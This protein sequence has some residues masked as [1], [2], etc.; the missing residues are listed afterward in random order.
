MS[1]R[2]HDFASVYP[3]QLMS[4]SSNTSSS[5]DSHDRPTTPPKMISADHHQTTPQ[6]SDSKPQA[7]FLT[8]LYA[9]LERPENHHMI[10][11]DPAGEYIIV[12]RP[13][14]LALH[15]LP[16]IYRQSRFASFSRQLNIYG[17]MRK[18][19]LRNVDPAIDDPD[20]ST[21]SHPT[22]NRHSPPEVVQNFKR[23]VPPRLPKPRKRDSQEQPTIPPPRST[24]SMNSVSLSSPVTVNSSSQKTVVSAVGRARGFSAPG[25]FTPLNQGNTAAWSQNFTRAALPP[26]TVPSDPPQVSHNSLYSHSSHPTLHP[27]SLGTDDSP[28]SPPYSSISSYSASSRDLLVNSTHYNYSDQNSWSFTN[29]TSSSSS[30]NGSLS[31]LLNPS[32]SGYARPTPT[33]NTSYVS[34]FSSMPL[35]GEH[36]AS[37]L[38]SD[39]RPPTGYSVSSIPYQDDHFNHD[40]SRPSSGHRPISPIRPPSAKSPYAP[41]SLSIRRPRRHSQAMS[42]YPSPYQDHPTRPSSPQQVEDHQTSAVPRVR[43]MI[44]LP[45]VDTYNFNSSSHSDFAYQTTVDAISD[46]WSRHVRPSTAASSISAASQTSS[47]QANTPPIHDNYGND[48]DINRCEYSSSYFLTGDG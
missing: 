8:K 11:W 3:P 20:A 45:S 37:S 26:L 29:N 5:D 23:R 30:H 21:W 1:N 10:R 47:S 35:Q 9:L 48:A 28:T 7:T 32:G 40:Y 17:F 36:S 6:K 13:E 46:G 34:P 24:I 31:S 38:S 16:S 19:N 15:V 27:I 25:S 2:H 18:V 44:Q 43:S 22:L 33:I 4:S 12:E 42:P 39:S 14:Q 41:G